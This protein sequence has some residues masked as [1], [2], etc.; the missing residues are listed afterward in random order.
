MLAR[1]S[2]AS[3][4]VR[5]FL[6]CLAQVI[7]S[8]GSPWQAGTSRTLRAK[9]NPAATRA[10]EATVNELRMGSFSPLKG[11][12]TGRK[13]KSKRPVSD[14]GRPAA[15]VRWVRALWLRRGGCTATLDLRD[16]GEVEVLVTGDRDRV[17][18]LLQD[19]ELDVLVR[20]DDRD[21][22]ELLGRVKQLVV[23]LQR[24]ELV[25]KLRD[26]EVTGRGVLHELVGCRH[27]RAVQRDDVLAHADDRRAL[28]IRPVLGV[29]Q[30][31]VLLDEQD[32]AR[33]REGHQEEDDQHRHHVDV[34]HQVERGVRALSP[35]VPEL[36][37]RHLELDRVVEVRVRCLDRHAS[38]PQIPA[39]PASINETSGNRA[40]I[41]ASMVLTSVS[42]L[43]VSSDATWMSVLSGWPSLI[44]LSSSASFSKSYA[45]PFFGIGCWS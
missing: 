45:S 20:L 3:F 44:F 24:D 27:L 18:D 19:L 5:R 2:S 25:V 8:L 33:R 38:E 26:L 7:A 23:V 37:F 39:P 15:P 42:N 21:A 35:G 41:A 10:T 9:A 22:V 16:D 43:I 1:W 28:E 34:R 31:D 36:G 30:D 17:H 13:T 6:A 12:K 32:L 4:W 11:R 14:V 40:V 29:G